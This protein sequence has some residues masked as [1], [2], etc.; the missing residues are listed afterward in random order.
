MPPFI[1]SFKLHTK[2]PMNKS[3]FLPDNRYS[4]L[5]NLTPLFGQFD[6]LRY[7]NI[8]I[9]LTAANRKINQLIFSRVQNCSAFK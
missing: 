5:L 7:S 8:D 1:G 2:K 9:F 4:T 3:A 6:P